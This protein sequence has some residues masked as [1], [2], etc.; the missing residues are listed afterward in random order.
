[1]GPEA[2]RHHLTHSHMVTLF[3]HRLPDFPRLTRTNHRVVGRSTPQY[4]CIAFATG[5]VTRWWWPSETSDCYWPPGVARKE[6]VQ[7]FV[8]AFATRNLLPCDDPGRPTETEAVAIYALD[9]VPTHAA[10]RTRNGRWMSKLGGCLLIEHEHESDV[11]G[12][13][14]GAAV[15]FLCRPW[16]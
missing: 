10:R 13:L 14:Y 11:T 8:A 2:G 16:S 3:R 7:A 1:M 12:P 15:K 6:T 4:N 9:G 5:E